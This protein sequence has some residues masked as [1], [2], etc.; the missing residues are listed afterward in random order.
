MKKRHIIRCYKGVPSDFA[1]LSVGS[2]NLSIH[3]FCI[4]SVNYYVTRS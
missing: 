4:G 1:D 3:R 2:E